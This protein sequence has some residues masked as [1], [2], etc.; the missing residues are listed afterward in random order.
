MRATF[1]IEDDTEGDNLWVDDVEPAPVPGDT[2]THD[3]QSYLVQPFPLYQQSHSSAAL[4]GTFQVV[5]S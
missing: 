2:I 5:K 3:G 1:Q 4:S